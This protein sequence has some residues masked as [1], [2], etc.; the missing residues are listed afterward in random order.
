VAGSCERGNVSSDS[1]KGGEFFD[2]L[3]E[4]QFLKKCSASIRDSKLKLCSALIMSFSVA[5]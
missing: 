2:Q 5:V 4:C 3:R 1:I